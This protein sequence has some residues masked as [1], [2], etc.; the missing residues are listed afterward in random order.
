MR[1]L[2][3]GSSGSSQPRGLPVSTAQNRQ[4][5][6]HTSPINI[7][8]AVPAFQ[9]S[10]M[11]GHFASSQTVASRCSRTTLRT[12]SNAVPAGIG[13]RSHAGLRPGSMRHGGRCSLDAVL[14]RCEALR[15]AVLV[16]AAR[17]ARTDDGNAFEVAHGAVRTAAVVNCSLDRWLAQKTKPG[18]AGLALESTAKRL[19]LLSRRWIAQSSASPSC[20]GTYAAVTRVRRD[21]TNSSLP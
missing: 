13:A 10:P 6:V 1:A 8:V 5:R 11:F 9:H 20:A 19:L 7:S 18:L 16:A 14:D 21:L 17:G 15:G 4:A 2:L 3:R 12:P